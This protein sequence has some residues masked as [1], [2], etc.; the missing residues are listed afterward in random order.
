MTKKST[1]SNISVLHRLLVQH[2][3]LEDIKNLCFHL[4]VDYEELGEGAKSSRVRELIRYM[5]KRK[6][7]S[8]L[9]TAAGETRPAVTSWPEFD[10]SI[11]LTDDDLPWRM[12]KGQ[13]G[14]GFKLK[15]VL[16]LLIPVLLAG[17]AGVYFL[18]QQPPRM[19]GDFNIAIAEFGE[20]SDG[21]L[22]STAESRQI[23]STLYNF[24]DSEFEAANFE[25]D[26]QVSH[27]N[28]PIVEGGLDAEKLARQINADV[29]IYGTVFVG[30]DD[31][32]FSP[33]FYV[34]DSVDVDEI[35]GQNE[36][37]HPIRFDLA[38][39]SFQGEV[40]QVLRSRA[41][42]LLS[43][44]EGLVYLN[45]NDLDSAL[46]AF[47]NAINESDDLEFF[48]GQELLH[49]M[50]GNAY[51]RIGE[52]E[53]AVQ[54]FNRSLALNPDYARAHIGLG[55]VFYEQATLD[56]EDSEKLDQA[57]EE[58]RKALEAQDKPPGAYVT[59][60]VTTNIGNVL[61]VQAQLNN[62]V[63][64]YE[65][66]EESYLQVTE[67]YES[68]KNESLREIAATAYFG[69]GVIYIKKNDFD[70]GRKAF[71]TCVKLTEEPTL[72]SRAK[73]QLILIA[74]S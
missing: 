34:A 1:E 74:D 60:K 10:D 59:E 71:Q 40:N 39:L 70:Q 64:L 2:F 73:E 51:R 32:E 44:T 30:A 56:W 3:S 42:I 35:T 57:L 12:E 26:I 28:M 43:F 52:Y 23:S 18:S 36:L 15:L 37:A 48:P 38:D 66:A 46:A 27:R 45:D 41:S 11:E 13:E 62:D 53:I 58:Y 9:V 63:S 31:A 8:V 25:L 6:R 54:S 55:N 17:I 7:L 16:I 65:T 22:V 33:R 47:E 29:I 14:L 49:L 21:G 72:E 4:G 5:G 67:Q 69:L 19:T 24:L 20:Q 61:V 50:I 68:T